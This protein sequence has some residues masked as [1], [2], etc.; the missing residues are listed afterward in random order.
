MSDKKAIASRAN[1]E[2]AMAANRLKPSTAVSKV[3]PSCNIVFTMKKSH[4]DKKTY[5][6]KACMAMGYKSRMRG[7][8]NP[9]YRASKGLLCQGCGTRFGSYQKTR[10]YCS[11]ACYNKFGTRTTNLGR[12]C[13]DLNQ[14]SIVKALRECG[15]SVYVASGLGKGFPDLLCGLNGKNELLEV[16]NPDTQYGKKGL[17][18][19]Q[20]EWA[21]N[22]NGKPPTVVRSIDEAFAAVGLL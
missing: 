20:Q 19:S 22:W 1:L 9:N 10:K 2:K 4:A 16:K 8:S 18:P 17:T 12:T 13:V 14:A 3:C 7:S 5:C 15:V 6:S 21:D 11:F